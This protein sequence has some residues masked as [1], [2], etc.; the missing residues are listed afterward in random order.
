MNN[1]WNGFEKNAVDDFN[2]RRK[3]NALTGGLLGTGLG[4]VSGAVIGAHV[5][6]RSV[7]ESVSNLFKQSKTIEDVAVAGIMSL[8]TPLMI[9]AG[10]VIGGAAGGGAG[11]VGGSLLG[12]HLTKNTKKDITKQAGAFTRFLGNVTGAR[13]VVRGYKAIDKLHRAGKITGAG[14]T[15]GRH[16][17]KTKDLAGQAIA[18]G[19]GRLG[20][21]AAG[22]AYAT[23][24]KQPQGGYNG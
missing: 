20:L 18:G 17:Q 6:M 22:V 12:Y 14:V 3:V 15:F 8:L 9:A 2:K 10:S 21:T 7:G 4:A 16:S 11:G 13:D 5:G 24:K 19:L 23:R 1:F